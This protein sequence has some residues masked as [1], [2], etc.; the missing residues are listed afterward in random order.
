MSG[1]GEMGNLLKQAQQ[2]QQELDRANQELKAA[3]IEG[4]AGGGAVRAEVDGQGEIVR[5]KL[6]KQCVD[7]TQVAMLEDLVAAAVRDAQRR[8]EKVRKER[9]SKVT[10]GLNLPGLY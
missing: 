10:G 8:S 4:V 7:P 3:R 1:F 5:I 9:L 6:D 2:M